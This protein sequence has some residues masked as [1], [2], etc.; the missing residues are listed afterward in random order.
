[1]DSTS[2]SQNQALGN[3]E[4]RHALRAPGRSFVLT[5]GEPLCRSREV[6]VPVQRGREGDPMSTCEQNHR[7][8]GAGGFFVGAAGADAA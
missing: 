7:A 5:Y 4:Q 8:F 1:M 3:V 2:P 6:G